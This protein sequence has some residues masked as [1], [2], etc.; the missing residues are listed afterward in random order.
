MGVVWKALNAAP[1]P[2]AL[3]SRL[4]RNPGGWEKPFDICWGRWGIGLGWPGPEAGAFEGQTKSGC[5][6]RTMLHN[7]RADWSGS[8]VSPKVLATLAPVGP[9]HQIEFPVLSK[10][11]QA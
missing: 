7:L 5:G 9:L 10:E 4:S 1:R 11:G 8:E 6:D 2:C 3:L